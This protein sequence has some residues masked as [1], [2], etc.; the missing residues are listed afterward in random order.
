M[1]LK[2]STMP[3]KLNTPNITDVFFFSLLKLDLVTV[4]EHT[5]F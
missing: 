4:W 2:N 1:I 5:N 3:L